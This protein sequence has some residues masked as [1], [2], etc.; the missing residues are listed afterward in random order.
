MHLEMQNCASHYQIT[1]K[2][3]TRPSI[4]IYI[5]VFI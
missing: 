1:A 2:Q 3:V 4:Y 5:I